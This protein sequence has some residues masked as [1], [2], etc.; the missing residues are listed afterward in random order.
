MAAEFAD[1]PSRDPSFQMLADAAALLPQPDDLVRA[2]FAV[3]EAWT[4][5]PTATRGPTSTVSAAEHAIELADGV[6]DPILQSDAR[7]AL[8]CALASEGRLADSA[9]VVLDR[10]ELADRMSVLDPRAGVELIDILYMACEVFLVMG[11][12][13]R[14]LDHALRA[15]EHPLAG[16]ALHVLHRQV[17][18]SL[19]LGGRFDEALDHAARMRAAWERADRPAAAWM[20]SATSLAELACGLHGDE[21]ARARWTQMGGDI[22][23]H[24]LKPIHLYTSSR[25]ALHEGRLDDA[26]AR[27]RAEFGVDPG[28]PWPVDTSNYG[29][30]AWIVTAEVAALGGDPDAGHG[31][32]EVRLKCADHLWCTPSLRRIDGQLNADPQ[33]IREAASGFAAIGANFEEAATLS[34]LRGGAGDAGRSWLESAGCQLP[35]TAATIG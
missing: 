9:A 16:G 33:L 24:H 13:H 25:L 17:V 29:A 34:L 6:S 2:H 30:Y 15:L 27:I 11:D 32:D 22:G 20:S 35:A 10:A 14:A 1:R 28:E 5:S 23:I 8:S 7:D 3:A 18:L 4:T 26:M 19:G 31:M 21:P 12:V